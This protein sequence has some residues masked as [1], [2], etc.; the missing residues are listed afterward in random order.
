MIGSTGLLD[1]VSISCPMKWSYKCNNVVSREAQ[2]SGQV[3]VAN[4][5][6]CNHISESIPFTGDLLSDSH[7]SKL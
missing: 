4:T 6:F 1:S 5:D 7:L 3:K 2:L